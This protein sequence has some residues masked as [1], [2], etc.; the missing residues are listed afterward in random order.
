MTRRDKFEWHTFAG[1]TGAFNPSHNSYST[2]GNYGEY[3]IDPPQRRGG[4]YS[5]KWANTRSASGHGGHS[6][7]WHDLGHFRSPA[8]AKSAAKKHADSLR[9]P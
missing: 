2:R 6:G 8:Q 4:A 5:L 1:G 3:H 7:L 9:I